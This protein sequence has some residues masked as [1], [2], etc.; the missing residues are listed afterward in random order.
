MQILINKN[1]SRGFLTTDKV[2]QQLF[3]KSESKDDDV[4]SVFDAE[5]NYLVVELN[6]EDQTMPSGIYST[7]GLSCFLKIINV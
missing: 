5:N 3:L 1:G 4:C 6:E 2:L 7:F